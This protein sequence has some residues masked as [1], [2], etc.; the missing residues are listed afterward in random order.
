MHGSPWDYDTRIP[1]LFW[2]PPFVRPGVWREP[3]VQQ[4]VAPTLGALIG[5]PS[6]ATYTGRVLQQA[7]S[8]PAPARPRVALLLVLDGMRA[9][10]FDTYAE[11]LPTLTRLRREGA[12]FR[13]A[14]INVLPTVTGVGHATIGTGTDPRFHGIAVNNL[15]NRV[16]GQAQPAYDEL[17][18]RELMALTLADIWNLDTDGARSSSGRAARSARRAGSSATARAS[19]TGGTCSPPATARRTRAG[20]RTRRATRCPAALEPSTAAPS[21]GGRRHVDGHDIAERDEV[22]RLEPVPAVRRP[23]RCWR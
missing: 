9:D 2:G 11:V 3:A 12:W 21:G 5:A 18:P 8:L 22:P 1:L 10:Y 7:P 23:R 14:R 4:D 15:F 6:L 20:R 16:T 19:S 17:D 13:E